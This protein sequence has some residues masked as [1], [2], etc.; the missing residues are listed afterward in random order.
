MID[1]FSHLVFLDREFGRI[2]RYEVADDPEFHGKKFVLTH[3]GRKKDMADGEVLPVVDWSVIQSFREAPPED[4][5]VKK[6]DIEPD[7]DPVRT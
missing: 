1:D 3:E 7:T 4:M 5:A 2:A 6:P